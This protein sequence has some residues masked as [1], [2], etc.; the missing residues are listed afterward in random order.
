MNE[1]IELHQED[2]KKILIRKSEIKIV[3]TKNNKHTTIITDNIEFDVV[4]SY[5]KIKSMLVPPDSIQIKYS[6]ED[7]KRIE[8]FLEEW[9]NIGCTTF[10]SLGMTDDEW[11]RA[12]TGLSNN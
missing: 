12:I 11:H 4:E 9:N 7:K 1:F 3:C 10:S 5:N 8:K 2:N 6:E